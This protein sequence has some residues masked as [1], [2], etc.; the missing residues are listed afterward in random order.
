MTQEPGGTPEEDRPEPRPPAVEAGPPSWP[1]PTPVGVPPSG[2]HPV[3]YGPPPPHQNPY[4]AG[5]HSTP[6]GYG[7]TARHPD[8]RPGTV[9]AAGI[10]SLV[11]T[12]IVLL[13]LLLALLAL[14]V[15]REP[16]L[17]EVTDQAVSSDDARTG[18]VIALVVL[19]VLLVWCLLAIWMA[20]LALRRSRVGRVGLTV[21]AGLTALV[22]LAAIGGGASVFTLAASIAV[23]VCL[24][25]GGAGDWFHREHLYSPPRMPRL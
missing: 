18:F 4:A 10:V 24:Y 5:A 3:P 22:S 14:L 7:P 16:L 15:A 1:P 8:A 17:E 13:V 20:V 12:G 11:S 25:T 9:L 19:G 2:H 21:S 6:Y 23:V